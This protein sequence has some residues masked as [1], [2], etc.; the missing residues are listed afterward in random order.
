MIKNILSAGETAVSFEFFPPKTSKG[1]DKL[2]SSI[3]E[4]TKLNPAYVSVT[5]GAGGSTREHTHELVTRLLRETNVEIVAHLTCVGHSRD[6]MRSI[7][8]RYAESGVHNILALRGDLPEDENTVDQVNNGDFPHAANLVSFIKESHP[9][10]G[11]GVAGFPEGH[12]ASLNRLEEIIH[13]KN[14]VDAG[15]DYIVTQLFFDNRDYYDFVDRCSL[16]GINVP[17]IAGIMPVSGRKN[18]N[19]MAQ[20]APRTRFPAGLIRTV[21][22]AETDERVEMAGTHWATE[23]VRDLLD[24]GV[25]GIHLYTLNNS[26]ATLRICESLGLDGFHKLR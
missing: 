5:Y 7:L 20:L 9:E 19:R 16:A 22:R 13:L 14:K 25:P 10:M 18:M 23:Q 8:N 26:S 6:E 11:V 3:T 21:N 4:L 24:R 1:W 12:P 2:F 17:V 15:A